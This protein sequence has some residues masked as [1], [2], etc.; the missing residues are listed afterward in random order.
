MRIFLCCIVACVFAAGSTNI[1]AQ[2]KSPFK[3]DATAKKKKTPARQI[4]VGLPPETSARLMHERAMMQARSRRARIES[5]KWAGISLMRP[6][7]RIGWPSF[8]EWG[9]L[10]S[11][12]WRWGSGGS[13]LRL[14]W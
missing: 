14:Q 10:G 12:P 7:V 4:R 9:A 5:R 11:S 2:D 1:S 6:N 3:F 8:M 13:Q